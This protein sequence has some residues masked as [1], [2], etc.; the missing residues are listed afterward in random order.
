MNVFTLETGACYEGG[1]LQAVRTSRE[2]LEE[3]PEYQ[4]FIT[5]Y[6]EHADGMYWLRITEWDAETGSRNGVFSAR[7]RWPLKDGGA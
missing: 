5:E 4:D 2:S 1:E 7:Y 6:E 3:T